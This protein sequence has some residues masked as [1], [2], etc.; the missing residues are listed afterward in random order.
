MAP[1]E[2]T[3]RKTLALGAAALAGAAVPVSAPASTAAV[4]APGGGAGASAGPLATR[5]WPLVRSVPTIR[6]EL[7]LTFDDGPHPVH[8]PALLDLLAAHRVRATFYVIGWR[9]LRWPE[10]VRRIVAEGHEIGNHSWR[11]ANLAA[12][13]DARLLRD[14]DR[15]TGAITEIV[16]RPP[17]TMRPPYGALSRR[18]QRLVW[19]ARAMPTIMWTVDPQDWAR[20]GS[21]T[22][23]R[24]ILAHATPGAIVLAHDIHRI[25][26]RA[27]SQTLD[28][29]SQRG[30]RP[31]TVSQL[32]GWKDWSRRPL[33]LVS[34]GEARP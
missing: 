30:L 16:G 4:T 10:I 26:I 3:R 34:P 25:T 21:A 7:A 22:V 5:G 20:P 8:T 18:Q 33:R 31:C 27:M 29:L 17:V 23:A 6:P 9:V 12:M 32:L 14:L 19:Q 13:G 1:A 15:C 24:R 11:H 2:I 28:G